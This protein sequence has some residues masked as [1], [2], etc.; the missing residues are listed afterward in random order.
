VAV[1]E[2]LAVWPTVTIW[3]AGCVVIAG[4]VRDPGH[5]ERVVFE[6]IKTLKHLDILVNNAGVAV[7][8]PVEKTSEAEWDLTLDTNLRAVFLFSRAVLPFMRRQDS[9][10]II[11]ISSGLGRS[12]YPGLAAYCASK[13][14]VIGFTESLAYELAETGVKAHAVLPGGVDTDMYHSLFPGTDPRGLIRPARIA[15]AVLD[16][17][18]PASRYQSGRHVEVYR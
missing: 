13:F 8:K 14:A 10:R 1:T 5:A 6:T 11:N 7:L 17:A 12:G 9:G 16:L 3:L 4:D 18:D 15:A 2:K